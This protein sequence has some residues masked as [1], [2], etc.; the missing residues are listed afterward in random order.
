MDGRMD[1]IPSTALHKT[2]RRSEVFRLPG[3]ERISD[4]C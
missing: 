3:G 4:V 2:K 1:G